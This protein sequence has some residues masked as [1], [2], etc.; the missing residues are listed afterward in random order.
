[1][2]VDSHCHINFDPLSEDTD[3][4][5]QRAH[6]MGVEHMLCVSVNMEDFPQVLALAQAHDFIF[7][8]V[9][10]HPNHD[11]GEEPTVEMLVSHAADPDVVAIGETGLDY[12]RSS[13]DMTWQKDRFARH[14]H[15]G[16]ESDKPLIIHTRDA[17]TDTMDMLKAEN[18]EKCGGVMH[19]FAE[20]WATAKKALDIGFY[21]SFSGILTFKNAQDMR[22]VAKKV[23]LDLLLVETDSPYLAPVPKRGKTN[24]PAY[25][26][27]VADALADVK[28]VSKEEVSMITT[29]N[30][31]NLFKAAHRREAA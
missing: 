7:A 8:S 12:F 17:A 28:G 20:D 31:F 26:S 19:C 23:P 22:D 21:I 5:I 4:V 14:I 3:G 30:F 10:V 24:E 13:G 9:G 18:A 2:L 11:E 1:M 29:N 27:Y 16:I 25:T 15:A 6:E